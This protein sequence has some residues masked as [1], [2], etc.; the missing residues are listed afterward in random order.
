[1]VIENSG[2]EFKWYLNLFKDSSVENLL[3]KKPLERI[4]F[5]TLLED[6]KFIAEEGKLLFE[7]DSY[8]FKIYPV[9]S[10]EKSKLNG[11]VE[12]IKIVLLGDNGKRIF[13]KYYP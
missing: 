2:Q 10:K 3:F 6:C 9:F 13:S 5:R 7:N 11:I 12:M 4:H 8:N 1:M